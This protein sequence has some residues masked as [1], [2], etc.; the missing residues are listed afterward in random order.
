MKD[1]Y[2]QRKPR[3]GIFKQS[4][5]ARNRVGI[6]LS[7]RPARLRRLEGIDSWA[8]QT[9]K[10]TGSAVTCQLSPAQRERWNCWSQYA[11]LLNNRKILNPLLNRNKGY[12]IQINPIKKHRIFS[13][14]KCTTENGGYM[15]LL[16]LWRDSV[17][18]WFLN[19]LKI[20]NVW[21]RTF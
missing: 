17:T 14:I 20:L 11:P 7:Y 18:R 19:L 15:L 9:F 13:A 6:G 3:A 4:M 5:G 8:P 21:K 10:N 12:W 1:E 16:Y 2:W